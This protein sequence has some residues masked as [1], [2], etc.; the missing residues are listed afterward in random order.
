MS[1]FHNQCNKDVHRKTYEFSWCMYSCTLLRLTGIRSE[2]IT[3]ITL[4]M[5]VHE[6]TEYSKYI[7]KYN[8]IFICNGHI[9]QMYLYNCLRICNSLQCNAIN[10]IY[11]VT[12]QGRFG[13]REWWD[14]THFMYTYIR[15]ANLNLMQITTHTRHYTTGKCK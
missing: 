13:G 3:Y 4:L 14:C 9:R 12:V 15:S 5:L 2:A 1:T 11:A 10:N 7:Y 6:S 8:S